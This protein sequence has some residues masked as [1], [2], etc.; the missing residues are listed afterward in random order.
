MKNRDAERSTLG[1]VATLPLEAKLN[2]GGSA[3]RAELIEILTREI[4]H[5]MQTEGGDEPREVWRR[6]LLVE[7]LRV[8]RRV[9]ERE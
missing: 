1:M 6:K 9:V 2:A 4:A 8:A 3:A 7:C 5:Q